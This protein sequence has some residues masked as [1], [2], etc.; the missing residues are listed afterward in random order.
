MARF[1]PQNLDQMIGDADQLVADDGDNE[2]NPLIRFISK[3]E[4]KR[5][6]CHLVDTEMREDLAIKSGPEISGVRI[7]FQEFVI[8]CSVK[9]DNF[10]EFSLGDT[11]QII[12]HDRNFQ[13]E[14]SILDIDDIEIHIDF[15][16][17]IYR[18]LRGDQRE[19]SYTI[20]HRNLAG[21][22][23]NILENFQG[24]LKWSIMIY[25]GSF[26]MRQ[27][28]LGL[29]LRPGMI[30]NIKKPN[31][32][33]IVMVCKYNAEQ[34]R[35][36]FLC[37]VEDEEVKERFDSLYNVS[38]HCSSEVYSRM[39]KAIIN[40]TGRDDYF[41]T[42]ILLGDREIINLTENRPIEYLRNCPNLN[43]S[44]LSAVNKALGSSFL[45]IEGSQGTGKTT[46]ASVIILNLVRHYG[47]VLVVAQSNKAADELASRLLG[48]N[49]KMIRLYSFTRQ[50]I[51]IRK[52]QRISF[53]RKL[54]LMINRL[55]RRRRGR[56]RSFDELRQEATSR[57]MRNTEVIICT[58][59]GAYDIRISEFSP[60]SVV[61]DNSTQATEPESLMP[62]TMGKTCKKIILLGDR[63]KHPVCVSPEAQAGGLSLSLFERLVRNGNR[64]HILQS[65]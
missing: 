10:E 64:T 54:S 44:Q 7:N 23:R 29:M 53:N 37:S 47:K 27:D 3:S 41:F 12:N 2:P 6:F 30:L 24:N 63:L 61:I 46:T 52:L 1:N 40:F 17:R 38:L 34:E 59:A 33:D 42:S 39:N 19:P 28:A 55:R 50:K 5:Y 60:V 13:A 51:G 22:W 14:G 48:T 15:I 57:L 65:L 43:D 49:L 58:C 31:S 18:Q 9:V 16:K 45:L 25:R 11:V 4:Y 26:Q 35:V 36:H 20:R 32:E 62:I 56:E 21:E 8:C